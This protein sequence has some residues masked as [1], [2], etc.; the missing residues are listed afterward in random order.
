MCMLYVSYC[1]VC[2]TC[3]CFWCAIHSLYS[4]YSAHNFFLYTTSNGVGQ[5]EDLHFMF[6]GVTGH[7][8]G[9]NGELRWQSGRPKWFVMIKIAPKTWPSG[10][11]KCR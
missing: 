10:D 7:T 6:I 3:V 4:L 8:T 9:Q 2:S 11:A 1:I 5:V